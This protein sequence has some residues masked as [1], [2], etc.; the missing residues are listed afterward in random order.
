MKAVNLAIKTVDTSQRYT[1]LA[2][3]IRDGF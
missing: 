3:W 1:G 2:R